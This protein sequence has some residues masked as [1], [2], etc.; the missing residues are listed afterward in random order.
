M[1]RYHPIKTYK[2]KKMPYF[3]AGMKQVKK[4]Q[5]FLPSVKVLATDKAKNKITALRKLRNM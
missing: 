3:E 5:Q 1:K 2:S 4:T